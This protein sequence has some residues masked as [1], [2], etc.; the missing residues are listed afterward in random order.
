[1]WKVEYDLLDLDSDQL[2]D[3]IIIKINKEVIKKFREEFPEYWLENN[4]EIIK[5]IEEYLK[6]KNKF[7]V[8]SNKEKLT[9]IQES[10]IKS[11]FINRLSHLRIRDVKDIFHDRIFNI[12]DIVSNEDIHDQESLYYYIEKSVEENLPTELYRK[13]ILE[14]CLK[15]KEKVD[16]NKSTWNFSDW[17]WFTPFIAVKKSTLRQIKEELWTKD[18]LESIKESIHKLVDSWRIDSI[19]DLLEYK[20]LCKIKFD[21]WT[22]Q[23]NITQLINSLN[24]SISNKWSFDLINLIFPELIKDSIKEFLEKHWVKSPKAFYEYFNHLLSNIKIFTKISFH[25][26]I[27][28]K[29]I[30]NLY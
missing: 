3:K 22:D 6:L 23:F 14:S 13:M 17:P 1:M 20:E 8:E 21:Y 15:K 18:F 27:S 28:L 4:S 26:S 10:K 16:I 11:D 30:L 9:D 5:F 24:L 29:K 25:N 7:L 12:L 19:L 2:N